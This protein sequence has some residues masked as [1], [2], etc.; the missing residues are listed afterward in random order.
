[1]NIIYAVLWAAPALGDIDV[2]PPFIGTLQPAFVFQG[3]PVVAADAPPIPM[4]TQL[5]NVVKATGGYLWL[6]AVSNQSQ[7]ALKTQATLAKDDYQ[8]T[9]GKPVTIYIA[10]TLNLEKGTRHADGSIWHYQLN[11]AIRGG[12]SA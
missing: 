9:V 3:K 6:L 2:A 10:N 4:A 8:A 11:F 7:N 5:L 12:A 1:M